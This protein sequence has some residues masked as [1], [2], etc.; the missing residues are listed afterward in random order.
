L[1]HFDIS[2]FRCLAS[3][4]AEKDDIIQVNIL[5]RL[6]SELGEYVS[7]PFSLFLS[8]SLSLF[9]SLSL[10]L[11]HHAFNEFASIDASKRKQLFDDTNK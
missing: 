6:L 2:P 3:G 11:Q 10:S 1:I 8:L 7:I 9:L 4:L 5:W